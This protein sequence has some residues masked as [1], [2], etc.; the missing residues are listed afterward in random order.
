MYMVATA[1]ISCASMDD[2]IIMASRDTFYDYESSFLM[3]ICCLLPL[4]HVYTLI[5]PPLFYFSNIKDA[6]LYAI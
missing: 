5:S 1:I 2:V 4:A 6:M 3:Y